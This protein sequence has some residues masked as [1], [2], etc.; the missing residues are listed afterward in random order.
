[1]GP[2]GPRSLQPF[3]RSLS[4]SSVVTVQAPTACLPGPWQS[5]P[6]GDRQAEPGRPRPQLPAARR[7]HAGIIDLDGP[8]A[9]P[10]QLASATPLC[11]HKAGGLG[12]N[13][14]RAAHQGR[15]PRPPAA[16]A[17]APPPG[18]RRAT[19]G[20]TPRAPTRPHPWLDQHLRQVPPAQRLRDGRRRS[21]AGQGTRHTP[22]N[23]ST[24]SWKRSTRPR[25]TFSRAAVSGP[26]SVQKK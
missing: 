8:Q 21:S 7:P 5:L 19:N 15:S 3:G 1:M 10:A 9:Q 25:R 2:I 17:W 24:I 11:N 13:A 4:S 12:R 20:R 26:S 16:A 22:R 14:A 6:A 18:R 23:R